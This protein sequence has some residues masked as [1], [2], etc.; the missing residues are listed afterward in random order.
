MDAVSTSMI[1]DEIRIQREE[2]LLVLC[3]AIITLS[4]YDQFHCPKQC[5]EISPFSLSA[6]FHNKRTLLCAFG[7]WP[8]CLYLFC[9]SKGKK[10]KK[11]QQKHCFQAS[12]PCFV[13]LAKRTGLRRPRPTRSRSDNHCRQ[14]NSRLSLQT[15]EYRG[16]HFV[17][18]QR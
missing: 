12:V 10:K 16:K 5:W 14:T 13:G 11:Q 2:G 15:Q 17:E 7:P 18:S 9:C 4:R 3:Q 8:K 6:C 1:S